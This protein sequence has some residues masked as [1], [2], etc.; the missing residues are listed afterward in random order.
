MGKLDSL[1]TKG[2]PWFYL[3]FRVV[4]GLLFFLHGWTKFASETAPTGLFLVAGILELAVGAGV[5][6]GF[7]VRGLALVGA[8]QMAVAYFIVH[9]SKGVNPLVNQGE[10]AVLFFVTFLVLVIYGAQKWSLEMKLL[11]KEVF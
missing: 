9:A 3:V 11:K 1:A 4:V 2:R 8:V 6:L 5:F 10:L 7:F